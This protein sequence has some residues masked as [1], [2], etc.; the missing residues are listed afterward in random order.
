MQQWHTWIIFG[1]SLLGVLAVSIR[2]ETG[3][4]CAD[5]GEPIRGM[6]GVATGERIYAVWAHMLQPVGLT[7]LK[8]EHLYGLGG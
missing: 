4:R 3:A 8:S 6:C 5:C 2:V 1:L 7:H